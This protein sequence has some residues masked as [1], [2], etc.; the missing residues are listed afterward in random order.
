VTAT[1]ELRVE[2]PPG[3][4]PVVVPTRHPARWLSGAVGLALLAYLAYRLTHLNKID[5]PAI[6]RYLFQPVI[7]R[8]VENTVIIAVLAQLVGIAGGVVLATMRLSRN[9]VFASASWLYIWFFRGTPVLVQILFWYNGLLLIITRGRVGIPFTSLSLLDRPAAEVITPLVA[10]VLALGLN[11]AAYMAEITRAGILSV[12]AG[13]AEAAQALGMTS[14]LM[15]R[16]VVLPQAMRVILPPTG[17]DFIS[18]LKNTAL[19]VTIGQI[20]LLGRAQ[21]IYTQSGQVFELLVMTCIWYL[22][23][24]SVAQVAQ[25]YLERRF[26]R[27]NV[28]VLPPTPAQRLR[29]G[30]AG[31]WQP[32]ARRA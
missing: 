18:M 32:G 23:L 21:A 14:G 25:Y 7:L 17:N 24:T 2:P 22:F 6:T 30:V 4:E 31:L 26:A 3:P 16:R 28:R 19:I 15:L 11:E 8:G 1:A 27:G 9:P 29:A 10:A 12:D 13:Q 20:E 5:Y